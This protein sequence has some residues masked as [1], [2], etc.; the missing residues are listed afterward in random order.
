MQNTS[1]LINKVA[2]APKAELHVH[3]EG[4]LE[5]ELIFKLAQRNHIS[6]AWPT[7]ADLRKAYEF[8]HLQSFLDIYYAGTSVLITQD[9]F[10]E[11]TAEYLRNA[12]Q[13]GVVHCEIFFDPQS[14]TSRGIGF[15]IFIPGMIRALE[16]G[17]ENGISAQLILCF[18]R[19]LPES[20]AL[21]TFE[22]AHPWFRQYPE[23]L[24]GV[25]LDSSEQGNPP[26]K[27]ARVFALAREAGLR[28]VAHAGEEGPADYIWQALT[29]LESE[30]IDHGVRSIDDPALL[31]YLGETKIPLTVCPLSNIKL[32]VFDNMTSHNLRELLQAEV[33][34]TIN[35]DDPA[36][37][38]GHVNANYQAIIEGLDL[39]E[40]E[41][42]I[43]L[44]NSLTSAFVD[45]RVRE[46]MVSRL[47]GYWFK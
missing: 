23:W 38:G 24:T 22:D 40:N 16:E 25:G 2:G 31:T 43:L 30:R 1:S 8:Q 5:P 28:R 29:L 44:K 7:V 26:E 18:L 41:C 9:D 39:T 37:F 36:Y 34:V 19:H 11:M 32:R 35:S 15:E 20:D 42:Y 12:Q 45:T 13:N 27:F 33:I 17:R 10:Y 14:H 21:Q 46:E 47:D 4:T 3:I 6:L